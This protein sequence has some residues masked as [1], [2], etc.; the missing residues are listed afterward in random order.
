MDTQ[1]IRKKILDLALRG[2]LTEQLPEDGTGEDLYQ[3]IQQEKL[4]LGKTG[5]VKKAKPLPPVSEEEMPFCIPDN[6]KWVRIGEIG[7]TITGG[8]PA[9]D[10][11]EYY[12]GKYPFFK[13][14]DLDAGRHIS[15]A[16]EYL[17]EQ[18]KK[19]S[20]QISK[21]SILVCC[22]GSIGKSARSDRYNDR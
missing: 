3:Q 14:S 13:P 19:E 16:S 5:I 22:I 12:G 4:E 7:T 11:P 10:H 1:A 8:T 15:I 9:K 17:T 21:G 6:W 18:G 20:R 2:K